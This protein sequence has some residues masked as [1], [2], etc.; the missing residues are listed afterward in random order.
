MFSVLQKSF[1]PLPDVYPGLGIFAAMA[2][3]IFP[4][5]LIA[6]LLWLSRSRRKK[7]LLPTQGFL[8]EYR[9]IL[10]DNVLFYQRLDAGKKIEFEN[11]MSRFLERVRVTGIKTEVT[12]EDRVFV[13]ASAIIPIF[14]FSGWEY[15]NLNEV[16]VYP[17]SFNHEFEQEGN[18]ERVILGMVGEGAMQNQMI[19]SRHALREGFSNKTD[20]NNTAI[21]EF[22][23]LIDKSDG[24]TD[25]IPEV[26]L[27]SAYVLPWVN[28][29]HQQ[30][31]E[32]VNDQS[33]INPYG[34][35]NQAEFLAVAGEYFFERP[36]LLRQKHP[37]LYELLSRI[38]TPK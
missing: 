14:A 20:K 19:L 21:H 34:A 33:D 10:E 3:I 13:A 11:R 38:F 32:I 1:F 30:I 18:N 28:M 23:H 16:L 4:I 9:R 36:D 35:T 17:D 15:R 37:E 7:T 24:A 8:P 31:K 25:G 27:Q 6:M 29:M 12:D 26:F 22:I 2:Y 5:L